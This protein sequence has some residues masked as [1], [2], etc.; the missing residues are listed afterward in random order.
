ME[1][2][3]SG[4]FDGKVVDLTIEGDA[5]P[6]AA[7]PSTPT[8]AARTAADIDEEIAT[9]RRTLGQPLSG[10]ADDMVDLMA[11]QNKGGKVSQARAMRE[12]YAPLSL[13][14]SKTP[15]DALVYG[16][17]TALAKSIPNVNYAKRAAESRTADAQAATA[18]RPSGTGAY[19]VIG[20]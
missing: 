6:R 19:Q 12:V 2:R 11:S 17:E 3:I 13:A 4:T 10:L 16:M 8:V 15:E 18:T 7:R 9:I 1:W 5:P 20:G 14:Q